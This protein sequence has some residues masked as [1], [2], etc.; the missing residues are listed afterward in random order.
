MEC[1]CNEIGQQEK[2]LLL[3]CGEFYSNLRR[4]SQTIAKT[5]RLFPM[6]ERFLQC[7]LALRILDFS[8]KY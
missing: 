3:L 2:G 4:N 1:P 6:P 5:T 8:V 7:G